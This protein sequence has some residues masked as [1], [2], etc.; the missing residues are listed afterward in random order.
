MPELASVAEIKDGKII[1]DGQ[2]FPWYVTTDG[3]TL[4]LDS[5]DWPKITLTLPV[6]RIVTDVA[7]PGHAVG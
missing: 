2:E 5:D 6:N 7:G 1:L 4:H 3:I